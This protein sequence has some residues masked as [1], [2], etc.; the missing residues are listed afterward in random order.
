MVGAMMLY[1]AATIGLL[2]STTVHAADAVPKI[3]NGDRASDD[4]W[5]MTGAI[6]VEAQHA[7]ICSSTLIAPDVVLLAAHC[8]DPA[9]LQ[10]FGYSGPMVWTRESNLAA[11]DGSGAPDLPY[12]AVVIT[13]VAFPAQFSLN[14]M[15][16][17]VALNHDVGL[18]FLAQAQLDA[19]LGYLPSDEEAETIATGVGVTV[20]GWG[21]TSQTGGAGVKYEGDSVIG[22]VAPFEFQVGPSFDD[23]RQCH[24]DSGG[25]TFLAV[26][27]RSS[28]TNRVIGVTSHAWDA[29][30]C[31]SVGGVETRLDYYLDWIDDA[32]GDACANGTRAWCDDETGILSPP[33]A[34]V[35]T[36]AIGDDIRVAVCGVAGARSN[37]AHA[38]IALALVLLARRRARETAP[39]MG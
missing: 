30:D 16:E 7:V 9:A 32:M 18:A 26:D 6:I 3:I 22:A 31:A 35:S 17:G 11:F 34:N 4:D 10:S 19:P 27:T 14:A 24:G 8:V 37:A 36:A 29:T 21:Q 33:A 38:M 13:G 20:V 12:D 25:P 23:V 39:R 2:A 15:G 1:V 28:E 5:P